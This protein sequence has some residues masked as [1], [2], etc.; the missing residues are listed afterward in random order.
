[1]YLVWIGLV[2]GALKWFEAPWFRTLSWWWMIV[3]MVLAFVYF[4]V[5]ESMFGFDKK[6]LHDKNEQFKAKR[7][8][9]QLQRQS[10]RRK[11]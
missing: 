5:L 9:A 11:P 2:L 4:E 8:K 1:M 3:P 6:R 10:K 7:L